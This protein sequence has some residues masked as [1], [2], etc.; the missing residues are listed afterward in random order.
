MPALRHFADN[1][2][3]VPPLD[4]AGHHSSFLSLARTCRSAYE[5]LTSDAAC[6]ATQ[7]L[8]FDLGDGLFRM[9]DL[10]PPHDKHRKFILLRSQFDARRQEIL[11]RLLGVED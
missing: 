2:A 3:A 10:V 6:W 9:G 7:R 8:H 11:R 5:L 1:D 4:T